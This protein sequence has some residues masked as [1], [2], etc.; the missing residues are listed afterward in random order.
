MKTRHLLLLVAFAGAAWF[1][2]F[3][4]NPDNQGTATAVVKHAP[5]ALAAESVKTEVFRSSTLL[6][7]VSPMAPP[8]NKVHILALQSRPD[9]PGMSGENLENGLFSSKVWVK[10]PP[11]QSNTPEATAQATAPALPFTYLGKKSSNGQIE[12][13]LASG[14]DVL[15]AHEN[16]LLRKNYRVKAINPP[17]LTLVY[18]PLNQIQQLSI[19]VIN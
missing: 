4:D 17:N 8:E 15:V 13:Y 11:P 1:A 9:L 2:F 16:D 6:E 10:P 7:A 5:V 18:L 19:G 12:V 14:D 3:S